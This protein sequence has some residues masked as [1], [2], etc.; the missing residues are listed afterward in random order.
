VPYNH[1]IIYETHVRGFTRVHPEALSYSLPD[2][3]YGK[4]W[5][6]ILDTFED[7]VEPGK[8]FK[9]RDELKVEGRPIILLLNPKA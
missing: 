6:K 9:P 4:T 3:K 7:M 2:A 1:S 8:T 5:Q